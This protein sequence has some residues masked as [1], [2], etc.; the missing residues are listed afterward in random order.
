MLYV[1]RRANKY[2]QSYVRLYQFIL[3]IQHNFVEKVF[4][5]SLYELKITSK[6]TIKSCRRANRRYLNV[7]N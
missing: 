7:Y 4:V 6:K 1:M 5:Y 3:N 2:R